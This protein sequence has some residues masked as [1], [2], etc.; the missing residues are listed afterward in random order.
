MWVELLGFYRPF[1]NTPLPVYLYRYKLRV[2]PQVVSTSYLIRR[3][4]SLFYLY[5]TGQR[6]YEKHLNFPL[7][8]AV[9]MLH[10]VSITDE[11]SNTV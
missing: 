8:I 7:L 1:L 4:K 9:Y 10:T 2:N 3:E 6:G 5:Q 11:P